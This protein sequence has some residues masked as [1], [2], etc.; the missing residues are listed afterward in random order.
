VPLHR[1]PPFRHLAPPEGSLAVTEQC[2][3]RLL[4]LPLYPEMSE[5]QLALVCRELERA[6]AAGSPPEGD[7]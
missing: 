5:E 1:T 6:M 4:S 3:G 2:A 7:R